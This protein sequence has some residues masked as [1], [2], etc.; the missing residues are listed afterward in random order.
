ME[1]S[2][3]VILLIELAT[4]F[5]V[6]FITFRN[7]RQTKVRNKLE[8]LNKEVDEKNRKELNEAL[9]EA[10]TSLDQAR[11]EI[12]TLSDKI[13]NQSKE[14]EELRKALNHI[15]NLNRLNGK[16]THE[17]AQLVMVLAEGIRDQHLDGNI[18]KA[19]AK[20]RKF[21]SDALGAIVTGDDEINT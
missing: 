5:V 13:T 8:E 19:I 4:P 11:D 9:K 10:I 14:N 18:T 12:T 1:T 16:Y 6:L 3:V 20:Y 21:E 7:D 2:D 17:L 15:A